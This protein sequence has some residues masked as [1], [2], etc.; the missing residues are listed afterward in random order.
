M[1]LMTKMTANNDWV[2]FLHLI[3][4]GD[5][6][7]N[8]NYGDISMFIPYVSHTFGVYQEIKYEFNDMTLEK[9][10]KEVILIS[11]SKEVV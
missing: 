7:Y 3:R 1:F 9:L 11:K 6:K 8:I 10:L 5:Y 2:P 4:R